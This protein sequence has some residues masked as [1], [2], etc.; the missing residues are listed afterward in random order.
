MM[1][2]VCENIKDP[3]SLS[4]CHG[5]SMSSAIKDHATSSFSKSLIIQ[6]I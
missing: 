3:G 5:F 1:I 6:N 2:Q 4:K